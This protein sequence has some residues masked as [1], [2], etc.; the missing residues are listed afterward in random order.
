MISIRKL[1][2][3]KEVLMDP[4]ATGPEDVYYMLRGN[5]NITVL[6]PGKI[7]QEYTKTFGHYHKDDSP[8]KYEILLGEGI[9]MLQ[10]RQNETQ[11]ISFKKGDIIEIP[12]GFGHCL[13]NTGSSSVVTID[14][15]NA[16]IND[17]EPI[18]QKHGM[19]VYIIEENGQP[20]LVKNPAY[21][22]K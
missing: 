9:F 8:E 6:M 18:R 4:A 1:T 12:A 16:Q 20:K 11:T 13:I 14:N 17:Y 10:S 21:V 19:A 15:A 2:D 5:P 22:T 3:L 7:G